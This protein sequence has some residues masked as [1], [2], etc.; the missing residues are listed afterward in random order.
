[1]RDLIV[2]LALA[3]PL[4]ASPQI[5][6]GPGVC[7]PIDP[8][9]IRTATET[10]GQPFP[11]S[12]SEIA[13]LANIMVE[14]S[15][16]D[17]VRILWAGGAAAD[18]AQGFNIPIDASVTRVTFS[19]MFDRTGGSVT[20]VPPDG[21]PIQ[22]R[23][24][25][26][27]TVL[28]CGRLLSVDAPA[29]GV[30]RVNLQPS[31]RFWLVVHGRSDRDILSAEFVRVGGRPA[32][33]GLFRIQGRPLAGRPATLRVRL[34]GPEVTTPQF[35]LIS[36]QGQPLQRIELARVDEDEFVGTID[37][38]EVAF[39]V[40]VTGVDADGASYQ[41]VYRAPF[42][43]E[44]VQIEPGSVDTVAAGQETALGFTIR[45]LGPRARYRV[46]AA[47]EGTVVKK[48]EP[49]IVEIDEGADRRITVW[50]SPSASAAPDS[51]VELT[52]VASSEGT[53]RETMNS[54]V[55]RLRI[56][57]N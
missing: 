39:R 31:D 15:R 37:L 16:S 56:V 46:T 14:S 2:L 1:M 18:A 41:R 12:S 43:G 54:V 34:S 25:I 49:E 53:P 55:Q 33:E 8:V 30:W 38:P 50:V 32:H 36:A 44:L 7:G 45:N 29:S 21:S 47:F 20:I 19:A 10:G 48:V 57:K 11:V 42:R 27:D 9:Y 13:K 22:Q 52:V 4:A 17:H 24:G 6:F 35:V 51:E 5:R 23:A 40:A 26:E 3:S 28:N